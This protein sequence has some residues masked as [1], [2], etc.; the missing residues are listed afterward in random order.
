[1]CVWMGQVGGNLKEPELPVW[2]VCSESHYSVL[3]LPGGVPASA[4]TENACHPTFSLQYFD[5]L[6]NQQEPIVL[7][8]NR[9]PAKPPPAG[10]DDDRLIPPMDLVIRTRWPG[11]SVEWSGEPIL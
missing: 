11:A 5:G 1:M 4:V 8:I 6:A 10:P 2:V 3:F 7:T 9:R